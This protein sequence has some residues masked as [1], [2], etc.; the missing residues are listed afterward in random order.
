MPSSTKVLLY[1]AAAAAVVV[2][3]VVQQYYMFAGLAPPPPDYG[4]GTMFDM[5]ATRYDTINRVLAVGMDVGWRKRMVQKIKES[6]IVTEQSQQPQL[7][8]V[9]TGTADVALLL[10][11]AIPS[12]K[13]TGVDPSSNMLRVGRQKVAQRGLSASIDLQVHDAQDDF[14]LLATMADSTFDAATMAFGIRNVPDRKAA[15]CQIHKVL[16]PGARFCILE[17]SEPDETTGIMGAGARMFIRY[18]VPVV[19]GILSGK[20]REYWHLQNSIQDFPSPKDFGKILEGLDCKESNGA[21]RLDEL[22]QMNFGSVQ[23]YV[24]TAIR[25]QQQPDEESVSEE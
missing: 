23:L 8:D 21:F 6:V 1:T 3:V 10:A 19:G 4:Q 9:A 14:T 2:A 12:A 5:I 22:I 18:V 11:S 24:S 20:P 7:L 16:K 13:I 15:L 17:F 25:K